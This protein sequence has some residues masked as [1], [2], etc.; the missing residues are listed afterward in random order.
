MLVASSL[1]YVITEEEGRG[2]EAGFLS[3]LSVMCRLPP[4]GVVVY[5]PPRGVLRRCHASA[6]GDRHQQ[7]LLL[8]I[9]QF[10]Y[11][12]TSIRRA[13]CQ[14]C[15]SLEPHTS[16]PWHRC[17]YAARVARTTPRA[18]AHDQH[19]GHATAGSGSLSDMGITEGD[20]GDREGERAVKWVPYVIATSPHNQQ[21]T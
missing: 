4:V 13:V 16:Y 20:G 14:V 1:P 12:F 11:R 9:V 10:H 2:E 5:P 19:Q 15:V 8:V 6:D 7:R 18:G 3:Q 17:H 21:A